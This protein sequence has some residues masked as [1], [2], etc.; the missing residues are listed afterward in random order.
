MKLFNN[1]KKKIPIGI[2][3]NIILLKKKIIDFFIIE[4]YRLNKK[5]KINLLKI[6]EDLKFNYRI[7]FLKIFDNKNFED[8]FFN[9]NLNLIVFKKKIDLIK[10]DINDRCSYYNNKNYNNKLYKS[11]M[12]IFNINYDGNFEDYFQIIY[13]KHLNDKLQE[14]LQSYQKA[15]KSLNKKY[16]VNLVIEPY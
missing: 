2:S 4:T 1:I 11:F 7:Y 8:N 6:L 12:L 10:N 13:C 16:S 5:S 9:K 14:I 3:F 15:A